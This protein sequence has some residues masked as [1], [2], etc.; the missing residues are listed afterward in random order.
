MVI[1]GWSNS[2]LCGVMVWTDGYSD[3]MIGGH[4]HYEDG[5]HNKTTNKYFQQNVTID[6]FNIMSMHTNLPSSYFLQN[7]DKKCYFYQ[8]VL[9]DTLSTCYIILNRIN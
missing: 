3:G 1:R 8:D 9:F 7:L 6:V 5:H 4:I 2:N